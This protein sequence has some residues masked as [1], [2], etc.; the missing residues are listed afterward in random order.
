M[1]DADQA[2]RRVTD[3]EAKLGLALRRLRGVRHDALTRGFD[4]VKHG[5]VIAAYREAE[6]EVLAARLAWASVRGVA[7]PTDGREPALL[8]EAGGLDSPLFEPIAE[9]G[10]RR[11]SIPLTAP[12]ASLPDVA[13]VDRLPVSAAHDTASLLPRS[14]VRVVR[15]LG[16]AVRLIQW[17]R[18]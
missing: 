11:P 8:E 5:P 15:W 10:A 12:P 3:A 4:P 7:P 13:L 17:S 16:E 14:R 1:L 2:E 6:C 9:D 18:A